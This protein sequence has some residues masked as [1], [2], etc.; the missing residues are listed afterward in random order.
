MGRIEPAVLD[1]QHDLPATAQLEALAQDGAAVGGRGAMAIAGRHAVL[2]AVRNRA[3]H[4]QLVDG[5]LPVPLDEFPA[6]PTFRPGGARR[7]ASGG[8][9]TT[10]HYRGGDRGPTH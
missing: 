8:W 7:H 3:P 2:A 6:I 9:C 4:H 1:I 5:D 10:R